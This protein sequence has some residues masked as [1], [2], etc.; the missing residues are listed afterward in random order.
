MEQVMTTK[1]QA[2]TIITLGATLVIASAQS[3]QTTA[4]APAPAPPALSPTEQTIKDIK[5]PASWMTWGADLRVRDEYFNNML[6]L[7]QN[8]ALHEQNMIRVRARLWTSI[9]PVENLSLNARLTDEARE[10]TKK[11][12]YTPYRADGYVPG[13]GPSTGRTGWDWREGVFDN[14]NA[15]YKNIGGLPLMIKVGRQDY[16]PGRDSL[17]GD[18]WLISDGTPQDGSWTYFLDSARA[19]YELKDLNTKVEVMGLIQCAEDNA[20]L[21]TINPQNYL[22]TD[23]NEKGA[24]FQVANSSIK[25][26]NLAGYFV[27]KNDRRINDFFVA[28]GQSAPPGDNADIYTLGARVNGML[29]DHWGYW[30]VGAYQFG[31]KADPRVQYPADTAG[32]LD[33]RDLSAYGVNSRVSYLFKDEL[34]NKLDLSFELLSGDDPGSGNDEM[35]DSLWGR[36]PRWSEIGLYSYAAETRIGQQANLIRLGPT[37]T[38][39]PTKPMTFSASY[40]ALFAM[41]G[42]AT[43][44]ATP[45]F[46]GNSDLPNSGRFR[47]H[48][49]SAMLEY[50]FN[51]HMKAHLWGEFLFPG[52]YYSNHEMITFLRGQIEFTF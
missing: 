30:L 49:A 28:P 52:D 12:G 15:E 16:I 29:D 48:F 35:F 26:A 5:N 32:S 13:T 31:R 36:W 2:L 14:L 11:A 9:T 19:A 6:T 4:A 39:N 38:V 23:Q 1:V 42:I 8:A 47:G 34:N 43:R 33:Y 17:A 50:R 44:G 45:L 3:T 24:V 41:E 18:G 25:A 51:P 10:W 22:L 20:W 27:Y 46:A 7:N 37:W 40:Y 21:P